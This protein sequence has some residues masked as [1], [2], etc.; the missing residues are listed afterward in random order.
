MQINLRKASALQSDIHGILRNVEVETVATFEEREVVVD[1][2]TEAIG[3]WR[4]N[5][6]RKT[7]LINVLFSIRQKVGAANAESGLNDLLTEHRR[8]TEQKELLEELTNR[9]K[10]K[11]LTIDQVVTKLAQL[12]E[13]AANAKDSYFARG[14]DVEVRTELMDK[15]DLNDYRSQIRSLKKLQRSINEQV[16]ELNVRT[17][18]DLSEAE[19]QVLSNED[20]V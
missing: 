4:T 6:E 7:D 9:L 17:T 18:I 19:V 8:V 13:R 15:D 14:R 10:G 16:L 11:M 1:E 3:E 20:L 12:E 5:L 2:M